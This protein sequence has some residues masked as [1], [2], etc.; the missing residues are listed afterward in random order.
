VGQICVS[1][2][3]ETKY[4]QVTLGSRDGLKLFTSH[5]GSQNAGQYSIR[6]RKSVL[7]I[8]KTAG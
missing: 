1:L 2:A 8:V 3:H 5:F 4:S 7:Q 6:S